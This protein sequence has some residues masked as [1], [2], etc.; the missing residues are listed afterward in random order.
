[1]YVMSDLCIISASLRTTTRFGQA[2]L[3][4]GVGIG[5][6]EACCLKGAVFI[7]A[8]KFAEAADVVCVCNVSFFLFGGLLLV[9][10]ACAT[11][12]R[13][14]SIYPTCVRP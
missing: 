12:W 14:I 13:S 2:L 5:G 7:L 8:F 1:M 6:R 3:C 9:I 10:L 4:M 11:T